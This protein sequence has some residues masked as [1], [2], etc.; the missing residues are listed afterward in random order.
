MP[1]P[2]AG[3]DRKRP[4]GTTEPQIIK[5]HYSDKGCLTESLQAF[6]VHVTVSSL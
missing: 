1:F 3:R 4:V 2:P 5:Q 6:S